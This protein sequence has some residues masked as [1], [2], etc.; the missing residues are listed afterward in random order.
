MLTNV[1]LEERATRLNLPLV[2]VFARDTIT[3]PPNKGAYLINL[4]LSTGSGTH[5]VA[6]AD[7]PTK[8]YYFDSFGFPP[9]LS[10]MNYAGRREIE[11]CAAHLQNINSGVCGSFCLAF[12]YHIFQ[13]RGTLQSFIHLFSQDE[14]E[15]RKI[16]QAYLLHL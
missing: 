8:L 3:G 12:L 9:P 5:W 10:V 15:N 6:M 7:T 16:L 14:T 4:D 1:D 11:Y 13:R 2:G